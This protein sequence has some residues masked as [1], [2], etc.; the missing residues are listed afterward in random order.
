MRGHG[1]KRWHGGV[2]TRRSSGG[3]GGW[4]WQGTAGSE[5]R[6]IGCL[7]G[8]TKDRKEGQNGLLI[9]YSMLTKFVLTQNWSKR[10]LE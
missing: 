9:L 5:S 7:V 4:I 6:R 3:G 2:R 10:A 8:S 1:G